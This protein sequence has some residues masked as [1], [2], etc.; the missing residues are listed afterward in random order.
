M[1]IAKLKELFGFGGKMMVSSL[2]DV[3]FNNIYPLI[4]GKFYAPAQVG[5]YQRANST[6][7]LPVGV[8]TSALERVTFPVLAS[9]QNDMVKLK[10]AYRKIL[11]Q[12]LFIV[13]PVL[14]SAMVLATP[15][16]R[17][18]FTEKWLPAV[19]YF[20]WL[21]I[22][23][24]SYPLHA[25]N[26]NVLKVKGR[27]DLFLKLEIIKRIIVVAGVLLVIPYGIM[28]LVIFQAVTSWAML[29]VN[30]FYSGVLLNYGLK[31][32]LLDVLPTF[33][34]SMVTTLLVYCVDELLIDRSDLIRLVAG[35]VA[36]M[37]SYLGISKYL[38]S[39][40]YSDFFKVVTVDLFKR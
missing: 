10:S 8:L 12:V 20:Q 15:M 37:L 9:I 13:T 39:G 23:G 16:F 24:I 34:I 36:G 1:D 5:F 27:S 35:A 32:Q 22:V 38:N 21:C 3:T 11:K 6:K 33:L 17:F 19:P 4:I 18:F 28:G 25:Y 7:Q 30:T 31:E 14:A 40:V 26:L 29:G 2:I